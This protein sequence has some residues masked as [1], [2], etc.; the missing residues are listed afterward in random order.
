MNRSCQKRLWLLL[1]I[2]TV[3]MLWQDSKNKKVEFAT[4]KTLKSG[5]KKSAQREGHDG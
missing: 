2:S 5:Q 4:E 1:R 3:R